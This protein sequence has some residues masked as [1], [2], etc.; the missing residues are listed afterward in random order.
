MLLPYGELTQ[1]EQ[2]GVSTLSITETERP[3]APY[4]L[5]H[6][7]EEYERLRTQARA[8]DVATGRLLDEVGL[9]PGASCLDAGCGPGET[10]RAMAQRVGPAGR[11]LGLDADPALGAMTLAMLHDAGHRQCTFQTHDVTAAD[12]I[13][14]APFDLVY[15]RLLLF[16]LPQRAD[17]LARL[18]DAV[19]PGGHLLV[20]DYDIRGVSTAPQLDWV[21]D[22]L[23]VITG[24]FGAAGAD[25]TTGARLPQL[26]AQAGIG[27]LDGTDVAG[28][29]EPLAA[30]RI[31]IDS[32]FRSLLPAALAHGITTEAEAAAT[33]SLIDRD[34]T[35][36]P[37]R[38]LLWPL[39]IGAW[40]RKEQA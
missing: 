2:T 5:G 27:T 30:G 7:P 6:T 32:V 20:Q 9:G 1:G 35:R 40:K 25:V 26:F 36:F 31:M 19:A 3:Q 12:P 17:V 4:A 8:W 22:V 21:H 23:G 29:I 39:M 28:R 34:A 33:L 15:A 14:G 13:L 38:P 18:W 16:H 11:V 24:A 37:D 10:M